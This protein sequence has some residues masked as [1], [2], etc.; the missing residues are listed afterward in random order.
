MGK[1]RGQINR[2]DDVLM[3]KPIGT[4]NGKTASFSIVGGAVSFTD[5]QASRAIA[6]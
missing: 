5:R 6:S 4:G 2:R 1:G 3:S